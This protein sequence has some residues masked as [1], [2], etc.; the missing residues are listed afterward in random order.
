MNTIQ[1]LPRSG[2]LYVIGVSLG[3]PESSTQT[4]SRPLQPFLQ[5]LLGDRPTDHATRSIAICGIYVRSS[6]NVGI[7]I[8]C[9][10]AVFAHAAITPPKVNHFGM[11]SG[12]L[13]AHFWGLALADFG[14]DP[15]SSDSLRGR[16]N[17]VHFGSLNNARFHRF[18][19]G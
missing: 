14:G 18:P 2:P 11:K 10:M 13:Y 9:N 1:Y 8:G 19:V 5:G 12:A 7:T 15:R 16:R 3:Q 6:A 4:A 17:F